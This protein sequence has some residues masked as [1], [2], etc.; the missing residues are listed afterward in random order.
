[1]MKSI[2]ERDRGIKSV[3]ASLAA[4]NKEVFVKF[5]PPGNMTPANN[6][7]LIR[8]LKETPFHKAMVR[9]GCGEI[10]N[11]AI[12]GGSKAPD[13]ELKCAR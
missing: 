2:L 4:T 7:A 6:P 11:I 13:V 5:L 8:A 1:M 3:H 10:I 12:V 9:I